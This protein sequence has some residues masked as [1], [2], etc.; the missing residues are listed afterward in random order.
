MEY[1]VN[2]YWEDVAQRIKSREIG[3]VIAGDDEPYYVYKRALSQK[4]LREFDLKNKTILEL[5]YGAGGNLIEFAKMQ[6]A[7]IFGADRS[8]TMYDLSSSLLKDI[9]NLELHLIQNE[10]LPFA[11]HSIDYVFTIT[12]LQHNTDEESLRKVIKELCRVAKDK[13]VIAER[14]ENPMRGDELCMGRPTDYYQNLFG[15]DGF[16]LQEVKFLKL[17]ASYYVC[18]AIRKL[19]NSKTRREGEPLTKFSLMLQ[20]ILLPLTK[21]LDKII[22]SNRDLAYLVFRKS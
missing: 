8:K 11:D 20:S 15:A 17:Q 19:L 7:K 18:G 14:I 9:P 2:E 22:P 21:V 4:I 16:R 3:N 10:T 6:T 1:S 13:I 5:G 12:V